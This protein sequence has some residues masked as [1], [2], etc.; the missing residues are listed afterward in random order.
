MTTRIIAIG[1]CRHAGI[2][3]GWQQ[4]GGKAGFHNASGYPTVN[5]TRFP[6]MRAMTDMAKRLGLVPGWYG[7]N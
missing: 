2:D 6:D 7:N 5:S 3:D 1:G 4:C